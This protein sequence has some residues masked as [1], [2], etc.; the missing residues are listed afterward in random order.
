MFEHK[1]IY[2]GFESPKSEQLIMILLPC[3][4]H[5][6]GQFSRREKDGDNPFMKSTNHR[7]FKLLPFILGS[8]VANKVL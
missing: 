5:S 3:T 1:S 4:L 7:L 6:M 8:A 2:G